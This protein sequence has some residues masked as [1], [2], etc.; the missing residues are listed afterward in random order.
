M[1]VKNKNTQLVI[2]IIAILIIGWLIYSSVNKPQ[3]DAPDVARPFLG[4]ED[5]SIVIDEYSDFQCPAC[6]VA[7]VLVKNWDEQ[8]GANIR[9]NY[10]HLP[11]QQIHQ[12]AFGAALASECAND[13][14]KF[15]EYH[16]LLFGYQEVGLQVSTLKEIAQNLK[17]DTEKFNACLD[18]KAHKG[19]VNNDLKK[20]S[21]LNLNGTPSFLYNGN[22]VKDRGAIEGMIRK[23]LGLPALTE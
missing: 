7:N 17:L 12:Y 9:I 23:D 20:A 13:Q 5:A 10:R 22:Y 14:G 3:Y 4:R 19:I 8:Y 2:A 18:S 11:L 6:K 21:Q 15:W 1:N 16:D